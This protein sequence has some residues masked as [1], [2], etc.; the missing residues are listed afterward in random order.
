MLFCFCLLVLC[1]IIFLNTFK[2]L[3]GVSEDK[4]C[5]FIPS[6]STHKEAV[7]YSFFIVEEQ[8]NEFKSL[9]RKR[10]WQ[11][12]SKKLRR[13]GLDIEVVLLHNCLLNTYCL[14][15]L[16]IHSIGRTYT[17]Q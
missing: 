5:V 12:M 17:S 4:V 14:V 9:Q 11:R 13:D 3:V 2:S 10:W 15:L 8:T 16:R 6:V 7:L 1:E